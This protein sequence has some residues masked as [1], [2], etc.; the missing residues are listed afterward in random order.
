MKDLINQIHKLLIKR[1]KTIAV[2]ESCTAGLISNL[3]TYVSGSS[4]YFILG[5]VAYSHLA[6]QN[7]LKIPSS[8][9]NKRGAVSKEIASRMAQNI[10]KIAKTYF[11]IGIT[12]IAG[13]NG[14]MPDKPVGTVFI[15]IDSRSRKICKKFVFKGDRMAIRRT[16]ALKALELLKGLLR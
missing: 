14:G 7:I 3:L 1:K 4:R 13:P 5:V 10:R 12:G 2:A 8:I 16:A 15:A 11:G 6:K 9:I